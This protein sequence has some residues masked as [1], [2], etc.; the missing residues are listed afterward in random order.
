MP[1]TTGALAERFIYALEQLDQAPSFVKPKYQT[2]V[3]QEANRLIDAD[4]GFENLYQHA[5]RFEEA[6]VFQDGPWEAAEKLQ[7]PLVAGSLKA[8]GLPMIIEVLSELRMLAIAEGKASNPGVTRTMAEEFLN[9]VMVLNLNLLFP[10]ASESAR[11][12]KHENDE[13]AEKLFTFLSTH[14]SSTALI[15][16]LIDEIKRLTAQRPIMIKRVVS[17]IKMAKE[18]VNQDT[19]KNDMSEL[20]QFIS[21]IEGP[22]PLSDQYKDVH[23]YRSQLKTIPRA[24][25]IS[26][27][28][29]LAKSMRDTGLVAPHHA[30]L[31]RFLSKQNPGLLSYA[32]S[33]NSKG[34]ANLEENRELVI[35]LIRSSIF[36]GTRQSVYGLAMMLERG[37]LSHSPVAPGLRRL[38]E[39]DIRPDVRNALYSTTNT[40]EG[41]TANSILVAGA[42][43]VLGQP[44]GV[45]QGFNP[46]CQAARGIS[47]WAQHAPG[48]LLEI[49]PRAARDGDLDFTFEGAQ[50]HS[51][52]LKGGLAPDLDKELDPVSLVLVPHLDKIYSEMMTRV[53][54]RGEDGHRW[55]NPAFYGNWVQKGFSSVFDPITGYVLDYNGFLKLFYATHHPDYNDDYELIY[56]NPVGI[57][58]TNVHGKLLGLHAVSIT[59]IAKDPH[60]IYRI[61]FYNPNNDG[62]Q[63]WGQNI[64]PSVN[65][66]GEQEGESSLPFEEFTSRLY[67][68]HYNPYEQGDAY[69]VE[70]TIVQSIRTLAQE[71]WG[72][73][74][75]WV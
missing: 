43:Q 1:Q 61:Y 3:Y 25:L 6:G 7:P 4:D 54:L 52:D 29:A 22:S 15:Q 60:G 69:A 11:M 45:G 49:I 21:A 16:T 70:N 67:A 74:Y 46:T 33:L 57:F 63:N 48:F 37:I 19:E 47:L 2:D 8:K 17:M 58:I 10:D 40:G 73:D 34:S 5:A 64:E 56:P 9:E 75:T 59:R 51:K 20:V 31:L 68:F 53:A 30:T 18:M 44:L 65:G 62:S 42:I 27:S 66:N 24:E 38:I 32:L 36:P 55:V 71:S 39:L 14:L 13:K 35:Q 12:E 23:A 50:I 41:V 72:R 28:T 26:E